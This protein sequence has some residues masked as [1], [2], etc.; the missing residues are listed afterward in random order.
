M[1]EELLEGHRVEL[2]TSCQ[3]SAA[4]REG[5][6]RTRAISDQGVAVFLE[7]LIRALREAS[8]AAPRWNVALAASEAPGDMNLEMGVSAAKRG[9]VLFG[10][11]STLDQVVHEYGDLCQAIT[12]LAMDWN[13]TISIGE[14]RI[15][16]RCLDN[17]IADAVTEFAH[18]QSLAGGHRSNSV[19]G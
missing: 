17:G 6:S 3:A 15:L 4:A 11:G 5:V 18:Q 9:A 7:Q 19:E 16:N 12:Q 14:F 10:Q 13:A 1:L 8:A 2:I